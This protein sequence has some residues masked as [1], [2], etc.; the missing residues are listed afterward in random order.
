M[1]AS[2]CGISADLSA[3]VNDRAVFHCDNAYFLPNAH[4]VASLQDEHGV[5]HRVSRLRR[6]AGH[7]R[8]AKA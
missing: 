4:H 8:R 5:E 2:R 7:V 1:L 6:P 3:A